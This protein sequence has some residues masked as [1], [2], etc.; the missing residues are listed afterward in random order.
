MNVRRARRQ[1]GYRFRCGAVTLWATGLIASPLACGES[2]EGDGARKQPPESMGPAETGGMPNGEQP[3]AES[4]CAPTPPDCSQDSECSGGEVCSNQ[5]KCVPRPIVVDNPGGQTGD[6]PGGVGGTSGCVDLKVEYEVVIPT[7]ALLIDRSLSMNGTLGFAERVEEDIASGAYEPWGC[8]SEEG[9]PLDS[10]AQK[11]ATWRWNVVRSILFRPETGIVTA[12]DEQ[13]R[14]GMTLY[15]S[16]TANPPLACPELTQVDFALGHSAELLAAM[17]CHDIGLDTPTR[18]SLALTASALHAV[19][20]SGPK[21]IILATDGA[22]DSCECPQ[23]DELSPAA[24][25]PSATVMRDGQALSPAL[26]EQFDVVAES[27]RIFEEWGIV[28]STIDLGSPEDMALHAHLQ[29]LAR[30]GGGAL[31][32]GLRP[33]GLIEAFQSLIGGVRSCEVELNGRIVAGNE[34]RGTVTL[35]GVRLPLVA[36]GADNGYR[37]VTP[38]RIELIGQACA[39]V[40]AGNHD[41]SITF[42]CDTFEVVR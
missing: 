16:G 2:K 36:A 1:L 27:R 23:Y 21:L 32:D 13:V 26:A 19:E 28:V 9:T 39:A 37:V 31:Y 41:L 15:T 20:A 3:C 14:F 25:Q 6:P 17:A 4:E 8:P 30:A 29:E 22:P 35:D 5:G 38:S 11:Y 40:K 7:V 33:T 12:L 18:E 42:P 10:A 24:C 34:S